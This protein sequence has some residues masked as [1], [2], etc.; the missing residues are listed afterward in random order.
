VIK[1][2]NGLFLL[3]LAFSVMADERAS[4][5]GKPVWEAGIGLAGLHLPHYLGADQANNYLL[6]LP[7]F[8]YRGSIIRADRGG[9][10]GFIYDSE[11]LSLRLSMG[12]SLPVN[13]E[14][15]DAREGMDD[16]DLMLELGPTLQ[17]Q[18]FKNDKHLLRADWPVRAAFSVGDEFFRHQGWTTNPRLYYETE[19]DNWTITS[20]L[21][22][23]YSDRDYH[24]YIY[25]V[26]VEDVTDDRAFYESG[27][28]F[29]ASRFSIKAR[30]RIGQQIYGVNLR[31]YDLSGAENDDSP[32]IKQQ[33][34]F[35]VSLFFA[36][37]LGESEN[38]VTY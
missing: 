21:G 5:E 7:Y 9:V 3:A 38:K 8:I 30:R 18:L 34:Y 26:D 28:G 6:P 29:T 20:T 2:I 14:D 27:S 15:N 36:W 12:A 37:V 35:A 10:R 4:D 31:Y 22:L 32:L 16:L 19:V 17:Y 1:I 25:D 23:V 33:D 13:S 11:K 24:A